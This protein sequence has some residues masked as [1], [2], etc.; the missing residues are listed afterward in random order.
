MRHGCVRSRQ[1]RRGRS[2]PA[3]RPR[4]VHGRGAAPAPGRADR[5]RRR[6]RAA[7]RDDLD[8]VLAKADGSG[9]LP[10]SASRSFR[11]LVKRLGLPGGVHLH[12]LRHS[13]ASFL[14]AAGVPASDIAAQ[15]GH[16]DGGALALKVYVHPLPENRRVAAAVVG[17]VV[18]AAGET[19]R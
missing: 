1:R 8:L 13:A 9:F 7:H 10:T 11:Q 17:E 4:P 14:A 12:T 16:A 15:L 18:Q 19:A 3:G 6:L 2:R 5:D